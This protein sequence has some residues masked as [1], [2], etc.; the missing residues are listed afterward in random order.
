MS[1]QGLLKQWVCGTRTDAQYQIRFTPRGRAWSKADG[2]TGAT[3]NAAFLA[4]I[5]GEM[6]SNQITAG[7]KAKYICFARTQVGCS[8]LASKLA[9][10]WAAYISEGKTCGHNIIS[11]LVRALAGV[12]A[13]ICG[14]D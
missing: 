13:D 9:T 5:Y 8:L 11:G 2:S 3:Q 1:F 7:Q 4:L 10:P 6:T 12:S 14:R